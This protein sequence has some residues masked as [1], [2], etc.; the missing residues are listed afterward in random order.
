MSN[1]AF[2][3]SLSI[4]SRQSEVA[5]AFR[6]FEGLLHDAKIPHDVRAD[7]E[8]VFEEVLVNVVMHAYRATEGPIDI[9]VER[10]S[11]AMTLTV[12]DDG[13]PFDPL[14]EPTRDLGLALAQQPIGGLGIHLVR[15]LCAEIRYSRQGNSNILTMKKN[16]L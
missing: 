10:A 12:R 1:E 15:N 16:L 13:P 9:S 11:N 6:W 2:V 4:F 7:L 14:A 5:R 8:L 3:E